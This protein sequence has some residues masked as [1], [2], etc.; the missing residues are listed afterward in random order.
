MADAK[1]QELIDTLKRQ[2]V[3]SGEEAGRRIVDEARTQAEQI[4]AQARTEAERLVDQARAEADKQM[5]Q[6]QSSL[7]IAA[8]QFVTSLKRVIEENLLVIPFKAE[9]ADN[10]KQDA[11]LKDLMA[12]FVAAYAGD[13]T[14]KGM[15]LVLPKDASDQLWDYALELAAKRYGADQAGDKVALKI[16]AQGLNFGFMARRSDGVV[17]LDFS[18]EAFL[19]L[20]LQYLSARFRTLFKDVKIG[21]AGL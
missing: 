14:G 13:E 16:E 7:E 19:N 8:S 15:Q 3:E 12:K 2:G 11:F 18:D 21:E 9:I 10:L 20:F 6:L 5:K 4:L 17:R 1:L